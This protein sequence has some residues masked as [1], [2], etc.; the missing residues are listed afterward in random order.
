MKLSVGT[1]CNSLVTSVVILSAFVLYAQTEGY[2][3]ATW[4]KWI[5]IFFVCEMITKMGFFRLEFFRDPW[6]LFDAAIVLLGVVLWL[7]I[8]NI[9]EAFAGLR[10]L[11]L[12]RLL[13]LIKAFRPVI[14]AL[15]RAF[16]G[17][18]AVVGILLVFM[19]ISV[20]MATLSFQSYGLERFI[21]AEASFYTLLQMMVF[22]NSSDI[23]REAYAHN[24]GGAWLTF[25]FFYGSM[26]MVAL[27][28]FIGVLSNAFESNEEDDG[29]NERLERIETLLL[30][31]AAEQGIDVTDIMEDI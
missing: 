14:S 8:Y 18:I 5:L 21:S 19:I 7:D 26:V 9:P 3:V 29:T 27:N 24:P 11:R 15:G 2:Q 20:L 10:A 31:I 23:A 13:S 4:T 22:D 1:V 30:R 16:L 28:L 17:M 25:G 6:N 12:V